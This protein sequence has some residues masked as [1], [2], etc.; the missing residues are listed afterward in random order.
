MA[1]QWNRPPASPELERAIERATTALS[2]VMTD[3]ESTTDI[4]AGS[5]ILRY[6]DWIFESGAGS[7]V[8]APGRER[9]GRR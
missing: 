8:M 7:L 9:G 1:Q 5:A 2:L 6:D 4:R 3:V